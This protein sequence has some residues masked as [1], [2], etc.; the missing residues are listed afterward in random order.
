M[1]HL[2]RLSHRRGPNHPGLPAPGPPR[3]SH[4]RPGVAGGRPRRGGVAGLLLPEQPGAGGGARVAHGRLS[5]DQHRRLPLSAG[6]RRPHRRAGMLGF[7][8]SLRAAR[9]NLAGGVRRTHRHG[10]PPGTGSGVAGKRGGILPVSNR[11]RRG[12]AG[13]RTR[14]FRVRG[15]TPGGTSTRP[16]PRNSWAGYPGGPLPPGGT[17]GAGAGAPRRGGKRRRGASAGCVFGGNRPQERG[18]AGERTFD[19]A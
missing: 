3:H 7:S 11:F 1:P 6:T 9:T 12:R 2:G 10:A 18:M 17:G 15:A 4:R 13:T 19:E 14:A 8:E 16:K 5:F